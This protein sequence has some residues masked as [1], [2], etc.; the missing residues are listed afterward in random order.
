MN[1]YMT[2]FNFLALNDAA[3]YL[4]R[5]QRVRTAL[6]IYASICLD[7]LPSWDY[8]W[9]H[10]PESLA[11]LRGDTTEKLE[12]GLE[13]LDLYLDWS[14]RTHF[15][16]PRTISSHTPFHGHEQHS[17]GT[18]KTNLGHANGQKWRE[19]LSTTLQQTN[20]A[21][22]H[23][24][25]FEDVLEKNLRYDLRSI[26]APTSPAECDKAAQIL[27][28]DLISMA[29][30]P[31][32]CGDS[33][34]SINGGYGPARVSFAFSLSGFQHRTPGI[35][36]YQ[37]MTQID[38]AS[39]DKSR[40]WIYFGPQG[41]KFWHD[42]KSYLK[43][44]DLDICIQ[45]SSRFSK[46]A[47]VLGDVAYFM[48]GEYTPLF[49]PELQRI[50]IGGDYE[51]FGSLCQVLLSQSSWLE[52]CRESLDGLYQALLQVA[53][54]NSQVER[55]QSFQRLLRRKARD[56]FGNLI[57][58]ISEPSREKK[59]L[60]LRLWYK[61]SSCYKLLLQRHQMSKSPPP[62]LLR[63]RSR[64]ADVAERVFFG[65]PII[66]DD[67][68]P[69]KQFGEMLEWAK[70]HCIIDCIEDMARE[71]V[72]DLDSKTAITEKKL[73]KVT[74][75]MNKWFLKFGRGMVEDSSMDGEL[76]EVLVDFILD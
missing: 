69:L 15:N 41:V 62:Q 31:D 42:Q 65:Q 32:I 14:T 5:K 34:F 4:D 38:S 45:Q 25:H 30:L 68:D 76:Q 52:N 51:E 18:S 43:R 50:I 9:S 53:D 47:N 70:D 26:F 16:E 8:F 67:S 37:S 75:T 61:F 55:V 54:P 40:D 3:E 71:K 36:P 23:I 11:I 66:S 59:K 35:C 12:K 1:E 39:C 29:N 46:L 49:H 28:G 60:A 24:F 7:R 57:H 58:E 27:F 2:A 33:R 22:P 72:E 63:L 56:A 48:G 21:R 17:E 19:A 10:L 20:T 6:W 44:Q 73:S 13:C 64:I 74:A